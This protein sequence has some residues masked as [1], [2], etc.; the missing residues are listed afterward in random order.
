M[1]ITPDLLARAVRDL[2]PH[3][4]TRLNGKGPGPKKIG[5]VLC[6]FEYGDPGTALAY[7]ASATPET[8][9][10][11]LEELIGKLQYGKVVPIANTEGT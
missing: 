7:V 5:F 11:A 2:A 4:N 1:S 9:K 10:V 8:L 3:I 6:A